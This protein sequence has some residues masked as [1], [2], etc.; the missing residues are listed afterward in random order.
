MVYKDEHRQTSKSDSTKKV[1]YQKC[2]FLDKKSKE[3]IRIIDRTI[4]EKDTLQ[5]VD[6]YYTNY[7]YGKFNSNIID[8]LKS[9]NYT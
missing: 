1:T 8:S 7:K 9:L 3:V 5:V 6:W 4:L 2:Y